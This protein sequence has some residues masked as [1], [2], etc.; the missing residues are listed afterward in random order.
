MAVATGDFHAHR[1]A[2]Y[3]AQA[4]F[5]DPRVW[6]AKGIASFINSRKG[7]TARIVLIAGLLATS[8]ASASAPA[9]AGA[10]VIGVVAPQRGPFALLG[11]QIL[12]G[13]RAAAKASGDRLVE[14]E[15]TCDDAGGPAAA[16]ALIDAK[17][18][19]AIG[20]LC[21][22]TLTGSLPQLQNRA[23]PAIT[24]SVRSRILMEDALRNGWPL[25]RMAPLEDAEADQLARSIIDLWK[26][27]PIGLIDDGTIYG[28][29]LANAVRQR[30]DPVGIRPVFTDTYRPGQEQQI[31]L[32]RRL[33]K[34][35]ATHV[36]VGG[37]RS[38]IAIIARDSAAEN[39]DLSLIGGDSLRAPNQPVAL[40]T[41]V[42]AVTQPDYAADP[43][44]ADA[45]RALRAGS[46][47]ADGYTLPAYAAV[48][49]A[50][51]ALASPTA[52]NA[53]ADAIGRGTFQTVIGPIAF[54]AGHEL[55]SNPYRL[56]EWQGTGFAAPR[57]ATQ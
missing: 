42:L 1:W 26:A 6:K 12:A 36:M 49:V 48:Q 27:Q 29:E 7:M 19:V 33:A 31:A 47:E 3:R 38:D 21:V 18:T 35:G 46:A 52:G 56:Q 5:F 32:V 51:Q 55:K 25:F 22:E 54:G 24:V 15:E 4:N 17:V 43:Q 50:H 40:R 2:F 45:V 57:P 37:D 34:A 41:G 9:S 11:N 8:I 16:Q 14:V 44:A 23:I 39:I 10:A 13:A 53:V 20:F 28:R 30:L